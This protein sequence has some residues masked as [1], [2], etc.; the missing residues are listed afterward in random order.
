MPYA[1]PSCQLPRARTGDS[2]SI[3]PNRGGIPCQRQDTS[4]TPGAFPVAPADQWLDATSGRIA[5]CAHS[6][7]TAVHWVHELA[8]TGLYVPSRKHGPKWGPT[9]LVIAQELSAL[10]ECRP[11]IAYLMRKLKV[12]E[13][14]IQYHLGLLRE[15]GLL[16]YRVKGTRLSGQPNQTSVFERI[17]PAAFDEA[18][19]IRTIQRDETMPAYTRV[20]VGAAPEKQGLLGK[21]ARKATRKRRRPR[22]QTV[23]SRTRCT[24]MQ[25]GTSAVDTAGTTHFP[26]ESKLASGQSKSPTPKK[27][28]AQ[29][30]GRRKLNRVGRRYQ[31]AREVMSIAPW[32]SRGSW[33]RL[34][35]ILR[36]V[37][38][39]GWTALE[40]Q[41][42]AEATPLTAAE[43]RR[44]SG[45]L[46]HRL[47]GAHLLYTTPQRRKTAVLAWQESRVQEKARHRGYETLGGGPA[48]ASVQRIVRDALAHSRQP[49]AEDLEAAVSYGHDDSQHVD[50]DTL[51]EATVV[52]LRAAAEANPQIILDAIPVMGE[53][54]ARRLYTN[55][56]VDRALTR[57]STNVRISMPWQEAATYA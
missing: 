27:S 30:G 39:A 22:K 47:K 38:D 5:T 42:V 29:A 15:T 31:L 8:K 16:V 23:S 54:D 34:A 3:S 1:S 9:T 35:W 7:M 37:A 53:A 56:L 43:V 18:H 33:K 10:T 25:G 55:Q 51:D 13:R 57:Y 41:A 46:A 17:I 50:I 48:R 40:V 45:M 2:P 44:P 49:S 21:L 11:G 14:T 36:D 24:P 52:D 28:K 20:P 6:W 12:S 19:G 4:K 32:L 26:P